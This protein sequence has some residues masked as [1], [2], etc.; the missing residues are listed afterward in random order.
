M[1]SKEELFAGYF[2]VIHEGYIEAFGRHPEA[3]IGIFN[4]E[5]LAEITYLRKDIRALSP[6]NAKLAIEGLGRQTI[7]IGRLALE[8]ALEKPIVMP[9]DDISRF[10]IKKHPYANITTEPVFLRWDRDNSSEQS[11][12]IPDRIIT[13]MDDEV[14]KTINREAGFSTNWWRHVSATI[15]DKEGICVSGHSSSV[16]TEYT[17][18]IDGDPRITSK[19]GEAIERSIDIH[20]E[21]RI[22]AEASRQGIT[23]EGKSICVSTFPCPNCA[24]L[25]AISGIKSCYFIDGYSMLDGYSILKD[26]GVEIIKLDIKLQPEDPRILK[27]YPTSQS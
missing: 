15:F 24:K 14:I 10:I 18:W 8:N 22:I 9:D 16:P 1:S 3:T 17:S 13:S 20:A 27:P 5:I 26:F 19:K 4:N 11:N 6:E 7:I 2:P 23:L 12:I 25:I 21:A